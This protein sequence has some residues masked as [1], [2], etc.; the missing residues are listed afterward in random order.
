MVRT[1]HEI[2]VY[3]NTVCFFCFL[4]FL[5]QSN[6]LLFPFS[7]CFEF[8]FT[9]K[10]PWQFQHKHV[11]K[12]ERRLT[13]GKSR[14]QH[15]SHLHNSVPCSMLPALG[16][17]ALCFCSGSPCSKQFQRLVVALK[18]SGWPS[19]ISL[20]ATKV[21]LS[22]CQAADICSCVLGLREVFQYR[23]ARCRNLFCVIRK[24]SPCLLFVQ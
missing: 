24:K 16:S 20:N 9:Q 6:K 21:L 4:P 15:V 10:H 18:P 3:S 8:N 5:S 17:Y 22:H 13:G 12:S 1:K 7:S 2:I 14:L 19:L 11:T 23:E